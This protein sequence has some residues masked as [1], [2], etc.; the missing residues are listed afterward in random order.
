MF[1]ASQGVQRES[2]RGAEI[3]YSRHVARRTSAETFPNVSQSVPASGVS[4]LAKRGVRGVL[5]STVGSGGGAGV[6]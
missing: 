6:V 4:P 2:G 3:P 1:D 5:L